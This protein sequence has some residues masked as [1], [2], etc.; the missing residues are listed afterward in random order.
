[1]ANPNDNLRRLYQNGLKHFSLPDFDTFQQDMRDEEK[2]KRFYNNMQQAYSPPDFDT[3]SQ[4]IGA[5]T[6]PPAQ[7][8]AQAQPQQTTSTVKPVTDNTAQQA[9]VQPTVQTSS[10]P[11]QPEGWKPTP[12]QQRAFKM[13]IDEANA[14]LKKQGE[15]FKQRM[16]GIE[17]GNRPG[18]FMG[19]RE[20]NPLT[21]KMET[22]YYTTR[23]ERVGT[24]MEQSHANT[25]YH[26]WWENNTEAGKRS[27][28][29]RLQREFDENF[30]IC[31][32]VI[33]LPR[34]KTQQNRHGRP[35]R[36]P[37]MQRQSAIAKQPISMCRILR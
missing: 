31:G 20:F 36:A 4:D 8:Q 3:F 2:R 13:Q 34:V 6:P 33:I 28:E 5:V 10:Q 32:N 17:K 1:M 35:Q 27:K 9:S 30:R 18:A 19:E 11:A 16:E 29:Q 25:E 15:E 21:G 12:M 22:H 7:P 26:N 37:T 23:G 14:R 24:R